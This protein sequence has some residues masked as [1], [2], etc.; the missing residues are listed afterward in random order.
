MERRGARSHCRWTCG[1]TEAVEYLLLG[2]YDAEGLL[3][4][5]RRARVPSNAAEIGR[6]LGRLKGGEGFTGRAPGGKNRWSG[7]ER[8]PVPL[9][10]ELVAGLSADHITSDHMRH[11]ARLLRWWPDKAPESCTID[12]IR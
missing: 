5:L 12:Q 2:L 4:Y 7:K 3:H 6:L 1:R 10:P 11:G 9:R 8:K